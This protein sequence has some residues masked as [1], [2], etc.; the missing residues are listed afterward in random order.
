MRPK[1]AQCPTYRNAPHPPM[2][3]P[4]VSLWIAQLPAPAP[5]DGTP[6]RTM[7]DAGYR[8]YWPAVEI[9]VGLGMLMVGCFIHV[10]RTGWRPSHLT[11]LA[12][13]SLLPLL[14]G[15]AGTLHSATVVHEH[16]G[17]HVFEPEVIREAYPVVMFGLKWGA[18]TSLAGLAGTVVVGWWKTHSPAS[19]PP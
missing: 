12:A 5:G 16:T 6:I 19:A 7:M 17:L 18:F 3:A 1:S 4:A 8:E 13:A 14:G 11:A 2:N 10:V 9:A 15:L